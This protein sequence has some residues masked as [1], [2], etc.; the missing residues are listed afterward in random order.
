MES[1]TQLPIEITKPYSYPFFRFPY[2]GCGNPMNLLSNLVQLDFVNNGARC[3]HNSHGCYLDEPS[4]RL[5]HFLRTAA[6]DQVK[7]SIILI[8]PRRNF[9]YKNQVD[10]LMLNRHLRRDSP[11]SKELSQKCSTYIPK[12][13]RRDLRRSQ[14]GVRWQTRNALAHSLRAKINRKYINNIGATQCINLQTMISNT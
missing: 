5:R 9:C 14:V 2:Y 7:R 12:I 8:L 4:Q 1:F 13:E 6:N 3:F 11:A 10:P